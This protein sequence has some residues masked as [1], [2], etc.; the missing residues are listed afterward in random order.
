MI[1]TVP[2]QDRD[3]ACAALAEDGVVILRDAVDLVHIAALRER[4]LADLPRVLG[5]PQPPFQF[6][7]GN[8]Q[9]T[10]PRERALLFADVLMNE[11]VIAV[12]AS[13]LPGVK[14]A[15]Y[16]GNTALN[17]TR[18]QPVHGDS[19]HLWLDHYT[20]PYGIVVN[21]PLVDVTVENG[22]TELWPGSHRVPYALIGEDIKVPPA[23]VERQRAVR[24]P[25]QPA[26]AAGSV[27]LR[28]FRLWHAGMP[29]TT[30]VPR[31]M[32]AMIHYLGWWPTGEKPRLRADTRDFFAHPVLK[33]EAEWVDEVDHLVGDHAYEYGAST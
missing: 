23:M 20:P 9:Q 1:A 4:M 27:L 19:C 10:P 3:A 6:N 31:P 14:N 18:R 32:L 28:D 8:V 21:V 5:L 12:T 24:P 7:G 29:N 25:E 11:H 30:P 17:G 13:I 15:F 26:I 22:A 33:T 16:S 2:A